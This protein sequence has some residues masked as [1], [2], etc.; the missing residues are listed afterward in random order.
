MK[1]ISLHIENF[2]KL[3]N[4]DFSFNEGRN[5]ILHNNGWGKS[6]MAA[7]ITVM[8]YGFSGDGKQGLNSERRRFNPWQGGVF[9]GKLVF[10]TKGTTYEIER[11]FGS[12]SAEDTFV[13]RD[14]ST[15]LESSAFS[16]KI[17]EEL[18]HIDRDS[19][20][21]TV[22]IGQ[23]DCFNSQATDSINSRLGNITDSIDL[24]KF[25]KADA[26]L[27][28]AIN[29]LSTR[30]TGAMGRL[31][32]EISSLRADITQRE[33]VNAAL[34]EINSRITSKE[35]DLS[36]LS[37]RQAELNRKR[38]LVSMASQRIERKNQYQEIC[39][40]YAQKEEDYLNNRQYFPGKVPETERVDEWINNLNSMKND[41]AIVDTNALTG[42]RKAAYDNLLG[43]FSGGIPS[44]EEI[45]EK[46]KEAD[47]LYRLRELTK[48]NALSSEERE[49]L[50][51]LKEK[52]KE[53]DSPVKTVKS[54]SEKGKLKGQFE[55]EVRSMEEQCSEA[56]AKIINIRK[57]KNIIVGM[58]ELLGVVLLAFCALVLFTDLFA[59]NDS[60]SLELM[61]IVALGCGA[62]G[63]VS[64]LF[65][66]YL[67]IFVKSDSQYTEEL[68][69]LQNKIEGRNRDIG[70]IEQE[71]SSFIEKTE[72]YDSLDSDR[73]GDLLELYSMAQNYENLLD[74]EKKAFENDF[75]EKAETISRGLYVFL[76]SYKLECDESEYKVNISGIS[77]KASHYTELKKAS[78]EAERAQTD[79]ANR[80]SILLEQLGFF[81]FVPMPDLEEQINDINKH[82]QNLSK[83]ENLFADV[84]KRKEEFEALYDIAD[85]IR[86]LSEEEQIPLESITMMQ[87]QL[88]SEKEGL[89]S[90]LQ[91][92][93]K[94]RDS[95][96]ESLE[97]LSDLQAELKNKEALLNEY[98]ED[99]E[100]YKLT[101]DFLSKARENLTARYIGPLQEG[102]NRQYSKLTGESDTEYRLDAN[103]KL[104]KTELGQQRER[105]TLSTGYQDLTGFCM[106]LSMIESMYKGEKPMLVL[107]DPF[108]NLDDA[109][110]EGAK[111][112][113]DDFSKDYQ[114]IYLTCR[115]NRIG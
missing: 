45:K 107:D 73:N 36:D 62:I 76:T 53:T 33:G 59:G 24:N 44:N 109:K 17:G 55:E 79:K 85:I 18:F 97:E 7:F 28:D 68:L 82:V 60:L 115:E 52:F 112:L 58:L 77:D 89:T 8:F 80:R 100:D 88:D 64:V 78:E 99:S 5:V 110:M 66:L 30:K 2:G 92:E 48:A 87:E 70:D 11:T 56:E 57:K 1:I 43:M 10:E 3:S 39:E 26:V 63:A 22:F 27:T 49:K 9:G 94:N 21:K 35:K 61:K 23:N 81:G 91:T 105:E 111:K 6:T 96:M 50:S 83:V 65:G 13:L 108:V 12:K 20:T 25:E 47:E 95:Y 84:K 40:E 93:R 54:L 31:K 71:I 69:R 86:S 34:E 16:E 113:L 90:A 103:M 104:T 29:K 102:F 37:Q 101:K 75:T 98:N 19:F 46:T 15:Y 32:A 72:G 4:A 67:L 41:E 38:K 74:K 14:V 106:R 42:E 114:I 51:R